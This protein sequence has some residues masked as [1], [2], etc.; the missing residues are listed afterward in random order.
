MGLGGSALMLQRDSIYSIIRHG[1]L[2]KMRDSVVTL[3][4]RAIL[5]EIASIVN[6][7]G[8]GVLVRFPQQ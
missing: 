5:G 8:L 1:R 2:R 3:R 7:S 4:L 6:F